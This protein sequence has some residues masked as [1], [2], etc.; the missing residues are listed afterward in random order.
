MLFISPVFLYVALDKAILKEKTFLEILGLRLD[1]LLQAFTMPLFLTMILFLGPLYMQMLNGLFKVYTEPMHWI[2]N[3]KDLTWIRAHIVAP[4]SEEF[5]FRSCMLPLL[6]QCF[7]P[8]AA[9]IVCPI[10]FGAAHFHHV[11][12]NIKMGVPWKRAVLVSLF[13]CSYTTLFGAY[14]AYLFYR[15]G[16]LA[17]TFIT[18]AFCNHM[19]VPDIGELMQY[20]SK[21][22]ACVTIVFIIGFVSW[23][24][25]LNPL[26]EPKWYKNEI[27]FK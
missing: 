4:L 5:S 2:N 14:S 10:F 6:L 3:L 23:C 18:H 27:Y 21:Q 26:T 22:K 17:A 20:Q 16:H 7:R 1:G 15:T 9:V 11:L 8:L 12:E 24:Y 25:L 19:G 13:Q